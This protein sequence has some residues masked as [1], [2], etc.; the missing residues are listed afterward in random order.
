MVNKRKIYIIGGAIILVAA[1][2]IFWEVKRPSKVAAP[3]NEIV[4][5]YGEQCSHCKNVTEF[6]EENNIAEKIEFVKKEVWSDKDSASELQA[7]ASEC[8]VDSKN[9]GVPFLYAQGKCYIGDQDVIEFF[10]KEAESQ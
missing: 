5:Y 9:I 4:Y 2:L 7:R 3:T 1:G 10:K 8:G 6:L